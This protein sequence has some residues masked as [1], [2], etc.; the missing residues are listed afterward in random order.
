MKPLLTAFVALALAAPSVAQTFTPALS[1]SIK[2]SP[3]DGLGDSFNV[4]PF[5]GLLRQTASVE[6]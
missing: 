1:A 5:L 2:D 6:E 3:R 4:A